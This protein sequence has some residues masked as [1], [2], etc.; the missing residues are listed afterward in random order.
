MKG[1]TWFAFRCYNESYK[2]INF[3]LGNRYACLFTNVWGNYLLVEVVI[4]DY[5]QQWK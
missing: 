2:L 5:S 3:E 4:D 1:G